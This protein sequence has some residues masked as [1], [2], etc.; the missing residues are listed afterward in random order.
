MPILTP[1]LELIPAS[2]EHFEAEL[3]GRDALESALDVGV[4]ESWPPELYDEAAIRYMIDWLQA[5]SGEEEWGLYYVV[6]R[7]A[8]GEARLLIGACGFKGAP[9]DDGL[10]ELGYGILPEHQRRG[11][12]TE[13]V[14]GLVEFAFTS[15]AVRSVTAQTLPHLEPSIRVLEKAGFRFTGSGHD[16]QAP[17]GG[18]VIRYERAR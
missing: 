6:R 4:P 18:E 10:V 2:L 14:G 16:P 3:L 15:P 7:A 17:P 5:H 8:L 9:D 11:Y 13:A 1:R 12:A